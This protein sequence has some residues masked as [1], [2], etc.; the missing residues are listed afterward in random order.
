MRSIP[1]SAASR[2]ALLCFPFLNVGA[3]AS[4][5]RIPAL[6]RYFEPASASRTPHQGL[7]STDTGGENSLCLPLPTERTRAANFHTPAESAVKSADRVRTPDCQT[8]GCVEPGARETTSTTK[9]AG[10][11]ARAQVTVKGVP[12]LPCALANG[13]ALKEPR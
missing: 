13:A 10:M 11:G 7:T 2:A 9:P 6:F 12:T 5:L 8:L 3:A 4:A 1:S